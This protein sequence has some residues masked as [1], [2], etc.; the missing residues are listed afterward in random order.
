MEAFIASAL[1]F[2]ATAGIKLLLALIV[3][4]V[5]R[6]IINKFLKIYK[7]GKFQEKLDPT[8]SDFLYHFIRISLY[9]V[10]V[11][12]I[13]AILGVPMASVITVI[14]SCGVA[15]GLALQGAL[16]NVAGSI[17][18]LIFRPFSVGDYIATNGTEGTVK[19]IS[20]FYTV[21]DT[22]DNKEVTIPNGALMNAN[23]ENMS[24]EELRRVDLSFNVTNAKPISEVNEVIMEAIKQSD[25]ALDGSEDAALAPFV[26]PVSPIPAGLEYTVRVWCKTEDYWDL[27]F[28]LMQSIPTALGESQIGGPVV[29]SKV[30]LDK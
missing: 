23:I 12:S 17:M 11:V 9:V 15:I 7:K 14:A 24:S 10:L 4:I 2:L 25:K 21:L 28:D 1:A 6:I 22:V 29:P 27:Y 16:A 3:F 26:A 13:I 30:I 8:V 5:G 18:I 19:T 20:M